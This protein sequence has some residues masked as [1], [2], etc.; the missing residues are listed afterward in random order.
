MAHEI[1]PICD[2]HFGSLST[3]LPTDTVDLE[4][5][6]WMVK[7][8]YTYRKD[9]TMKS[10]I[11]TPWSKKVTPFPYLRCKIQA[12]KDE[13]RDEKV[14]QWTISFLFPI[15]P[16]TKTTQTNPGKMASGKIRARWSIKARYKPMRPKRPNTLDLAL[17]NTDMMGSNKVMVSLSVKV[18]HRFGPMC[19][20]CKQST[21]H[22]SPQ[23]SD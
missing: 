18:C 11:F 15:H 12:Y 23:E 3:T 14:L 7:G 1:S 13:Q 22:P 8:I 6:A 5:T 9:H 2:F 19:Q 16:V 10:T 17:T 20:F 4:L 21:Q